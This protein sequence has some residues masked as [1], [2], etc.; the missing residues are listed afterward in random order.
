MDGPD[1]P[2]GE[3][4][5]HGQAGAGRLAGSKRHPAR[6][7]LA[8][9]T[10]VVERA[11][12]NRER[13]KGGEMKGVLTERTR[14]GGGAGGRP[15]ARRGGGTPRGNGVDEAPATPGGCGRAAE[16]L[17]DQQKVEEGVARS[18]GEYRLE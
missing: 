18:S 9:T 14:Q 7:S 11:G 16:H 12:G 3:S 6:W 5:G 13:E 1:T 8:T 10:G 15:T 4:D 17:Q 2:Q